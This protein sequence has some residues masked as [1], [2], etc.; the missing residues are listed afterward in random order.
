MKKLIFSF[1]VLLLSTIV[2]NAQSERPFSAEIGLDLAIPASNL[3]GYSIG[4]GIDALGQYMVTDKVGITADAGY[5]ALFPK[6]GGKNLGIIPIRAGIRFYPT[7]N[8]YLA[9]KAGVGIITIPGDNYTST[10]YSFGGGYMLSRAAD[11]GVTYDGYSKAGSFG[12]VNLRIA[13]K[14]GQ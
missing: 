14:F 6:S 11:L 13:Y 3:K 12:L 1:A 10:A 9:G 8:F 2:A 5:T 4:A 7:D